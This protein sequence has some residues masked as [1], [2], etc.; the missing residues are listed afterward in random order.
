[1]QFDVD[2]KTIIQV[3]ECHYGV[4]YCFLTNRNYDFFQVDKATM[5]GAELHLS[6]ILTLNKPKI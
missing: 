4:I 6:H 1:M 3:A 2:E 5:Q